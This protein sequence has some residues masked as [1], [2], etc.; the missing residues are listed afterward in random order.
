M[1]QSARAVLDTFFS[2][3]NFPSP[4]PVHYESVR[5]TPESAFGNG[6]GI[7]LLAET[8]TGC[9][10]AG[11]RVLE[12]GQKGADAGREAAEELVG[13][14]RCGG[15]V[16]RY[17]QVSGNECVAFTLLRRH[18]FAL[19]FGLDQLLSASGRLNVTIRASSHKS[20]V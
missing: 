20:V 14:L 3:S 15:C 13:D 10:L 5:E 16:D 7:L 2:S 4:P 18:S 1:L 8:S 6:A 19:G 17:L 9:R 11:S 12:R